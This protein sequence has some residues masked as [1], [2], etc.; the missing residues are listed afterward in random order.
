MKK[1]LSGITG[2]IKNHY[3]LSGIVVVVIALIAFSIGGEGTKAELYTVKQGDIVQ[4]VIVNGKTKP[5]QS[6]ELGFQVSGIV[7]SSNVTIGSRVYTG[8]TLA[9]LSQSGLSS[10]LLKAKA[11]LL[12][13]QAKLD[14]LRLGARPEEIVI[15][16]TNV[17]SAETVLEDAQNN[18]KAKM[19]ESFSKADD[20]IHNTIDQFFSNPR[21]INAKFNFLFPNSQ[22]ESEVNGGRVAVENLFLE[23]QLRGDSTT[24]DSI[25][26]TEAAINRITMFVDKVADAINA[27]TNLSSL[28]ASTIAAYKAEVASAR[29]SMSAS[30][31][32]LV[33]AKEKINS[34]Q[35]ALTLAKNNLALK[36]SGNSREVIR[37]QEARVMQNEAELKRVESELGKTV[38]RSPQNGIVTIQ[39]AKV[40]QTVTPGKVVISIISDSNLEIESN[41]SEVSVGKVTVGNEVLM[42][43]DAFP[44]ETFK[45]T[46][47]Y[48]EPAETIVDGVVNYKVRV[49]FSEVYS[50]MKSGLTSKL[51]IITETKPNVLVVP[52]YSV[53]TRNGET[54]VMRKNGKEYIEV[55]VTVG[56]KGQDGKIEII[57]GL[58]VGDEVNMSLNAPV[59]AQ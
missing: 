25:Q 52:Q 32:T 17:S 33:T 16:E 5:V 24:L 47:T 36:K 11:N 6:V 55:P 48:I 7:A 56:L 58:S 23:W 22:L 3:I 12:S 14:E 26:K 8:Q 13:E 42:T 30:L 15:A 10:E 2:F 44:G 21:T 50:Q 39:D 4:K 1:Y 20:A 37:A 53:I 27:Q 38:L 19:Q 51:E 35:S 18:L 31:S 46:V 43:F 57:S 9:A 34:A 40:G 28:P 29:I 45:G 54:F 49:A 41:V 59:S